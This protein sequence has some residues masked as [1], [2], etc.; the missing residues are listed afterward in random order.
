VVVTEY[1]ANYDS[2]NAI[3]NVP[4]YP[5]INQFN[6]D[7]YKLYEGYSKNYENLFL[8]GRLAE[9][10]YFN[11]DAVIESTFDKLKLINK[12]ITKVGK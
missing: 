1:P 10:K 8:C 11:M 7:I 2:N 9:F 3:K 6:N 12:Y 5:V 4:C